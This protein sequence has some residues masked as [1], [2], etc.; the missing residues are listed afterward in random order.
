MT[1]RIITTT[2]TL[3]MCLFIK[4]QLGQQNYVKTTTYIDGQGTSAITGLA[5]RPCRGQTQRILPVSSHTV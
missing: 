5:V 1:R 3:L 4:A 2:L